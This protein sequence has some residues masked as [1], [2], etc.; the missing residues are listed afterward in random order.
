MTSTRARTPGAIVVGPSRILTLWVA[1]GF[2]ATTALSGCYLPLWAAAAIVLALAVSAASALR[3][4]A[5]RSHSQAV[6]ALRCHS[7]TI[8]IRIKSGHWIIGTI[9]PGALVSDMLTV[10]RIRDKDV[11]A[12]VRY[13]VLMPDNVYQE[14]Y[15]RLRVVLRWQYSEE[16][17][18]N[19]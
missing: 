1:L 5:L 10:V 13:L 8:E 4:H 14:D 7:N 9:L 3:L 17:G 12:R 16:R 11:A 15:R 6:V 2:A 18:D 19:V